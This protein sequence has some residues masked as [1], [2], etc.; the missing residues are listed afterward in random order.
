MSGQFVL[1]ETN[2]VPPNYNLLGL[3]RDNNCN[4]SYKLKFSLVDDL[5]AWNLPLN[6]IIMI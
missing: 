1:E 3:S 4:K 2:S 5:I 6:K